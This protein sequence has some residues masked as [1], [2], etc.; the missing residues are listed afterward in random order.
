VTWSSRAIIRVE[1]H[2]PFVSLQTQALAI[3]AGEKLLDSSPLEDMPSPSGYHDGE[4]MAFYEITVASADQP[5]LLSRLSEALVGSSR[6]SCSIVCMHASK[7]S[8]AWPKSI[9]PPLLQSDLG[10]NIREAHAFNTN[11]GFSLDVF[12]VDQIADQV[13]KGGHALRIVG[14]HATAT[15]AIPL[16]L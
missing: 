4:H 8:T 3:E 14:K 10:L 12:V 5:K 16:L 1:T 11:D 2:C 13:R 15:D 7:T 9:T 6:S